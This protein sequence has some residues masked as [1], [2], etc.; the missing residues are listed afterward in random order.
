MA[1]N[2]PLA[3]RNQIRLSDC[4]DYPLVI[5]DGS[6]VIRPYLDSAFAKASL[7]PLPIIETNAIEIMRHAA[8]LDNGITFLTPFDI[9]FE[10]R[11]GRLVYVPVRELAYETQTLMLIGHERGTSAIASVLAEMLKAMMREAAT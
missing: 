3:K 11:V 7:E 6:T 10:R 1:P 4:V 8:I 2:H 5:A 9:E